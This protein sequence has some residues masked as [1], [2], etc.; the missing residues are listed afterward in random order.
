MFTAPG[1]CVDSGSSG[2][3]TRDSSS[4]STSRIYTELPV[5]RRCGSGLTE[6]RRYGI[7]GCGAGGSVK[8]SNASTAPGRCVDSGSG[9]YNIRDSISSSASSTGDN[10]S[11]SGVSGVSPLS[12][13]D[14]VAETP[15]LER[16]CT[17]SKLDFFFPLLVGMTMSINANWSC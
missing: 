8:N 7:D 12:L 1:R 10:S 16:L 17:A 2:N 5:T 3:S 9:T 6:S 15:L 13:G 14:V 11:R 4:S